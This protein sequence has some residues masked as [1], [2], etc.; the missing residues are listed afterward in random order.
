MG[1]GRFSAWWL[2]VAPLYQGGKKNGDGNGVD[3]WPSCWGEVARA[4]EN[5]VDTRRPRASFDVYG[6][7]ALLHVFTPHRV[8]LLLAQ[9]TS[10]CGKKTIFTSP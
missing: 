6:V 7:S 8:R 3:W 1:N 2:L 9:S 5:S 4:S 10:Y